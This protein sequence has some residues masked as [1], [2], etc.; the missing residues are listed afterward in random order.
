[1]EKDMQSG[2]EESHK[3]DKSPPIKDRKEVI[4]VHEF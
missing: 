4:E 1:M 2:H 3:G